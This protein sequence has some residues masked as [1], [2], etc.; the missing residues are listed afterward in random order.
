[1]LAAVLRTACRCPHVIRAWRRATVGRD[2]GDTPIGDSSTL[3]RALSSMRSLDHVLK[4][5]RPRMAFKRLLANRALPIAA[6][7]VVVVGAG[8]ASVRLLTE[9]VDPAEYGRLSLLLGLAALPAITI[10]SSLTKA[11]ARGLWDHLRAGTITSFVSSSLTLNTALTGAVAVLLGTAHLAG[12]QAGLE[13]STDVFLLSAYLLFS[14]LLSLVTT[15]LNTLEHHRPFALLTALHALLAP[16]AAVSFALFWMPTAFALLLGHTLALCILTVAALSFFAKR[17]LLSSSAPLYNHRIT[18]ALLAYGAP[19][20]LAN[21]LFWIQSTSNRYV[22]DAFLTL[23]D[24]GLFVVAGSVARQPIA[25]IEAVFVQ[26]FLPRLYRN[27]ST[28][29]HDSVPTLR[30]GGRMYILASVYIIVPVFLFSLAMAPDLLVL[31]TATKY[32]SGVYLMVWLAAAE[33][34]RV[35]ASVAMTLFELGQKPRSLVAPIAVAAILTLSMT[36]VLTPLIGVVGTAI[37]L[38]IG[39]FSVFLLNFV[40]AHHQLPFLSIPWRQVGVAVLTDILVVLA[41]LGGLSVFAV[42]GV[43]ARLAVASVV[44]APLYLYRVKS[45]LATGDVT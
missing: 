7:R 34:F 12:L 8:I 2:S 15:I 33:F 25:L 43:W 42:T 11:T 22:M 3:D 27:A 9:I 10:F 24:I 17:G 41:L 6:S 40:S 14:V 38:C 18:S 26:L 44:F 13:T 1:M 28:K 29:E 21:L 4:R 30:T 20:F 32:H 39:S 5:N 45:S 19:L 16:A 23:T 35:L 37:A 36:L 31:L